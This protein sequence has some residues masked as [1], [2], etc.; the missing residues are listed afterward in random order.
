[1]LAGPVSDVEI[2]F[3]DD[4]V[5]RPAACSVDARAGV[6]FLLSVVEDCLLPEGCVDIAF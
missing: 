1:M 5:D 3:L 6:L 4:E 2:V